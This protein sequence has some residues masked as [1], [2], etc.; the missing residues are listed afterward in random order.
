[1][2]NDY[3][4]EFPQTAFTR[5]QLYETFKRLNLAPESIW[6]TQGV[7]TGQML[8]DLADTMYADMGKISPTILIN[9]KIFSSLKKQLK[10]SK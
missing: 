7:I 3:G 5:D 9:P 4:L 6:S 8:A 2:R 1:M 10:S